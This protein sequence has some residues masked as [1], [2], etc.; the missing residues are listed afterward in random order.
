MNDAHANLL[1]GTLFI[2]GAWAKGT[3]TFSVLDK[4]SGDL[5]GTAERAS[6]E[7]VDGAVAAARR[8]F[9]D[10]PARALRALS[11]PDEGRRAHRGTQ[12]FLVDTIVAEAGFPV[13]DA[14]N[15]VSRA[16]QTFIVSAEEGQAA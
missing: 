3:N 4:F 7:Q 9:D 15:E 13:T 10:G 2:D 11:H 8:S 16:V 1:R 12:R 14:R 6:R 5:V